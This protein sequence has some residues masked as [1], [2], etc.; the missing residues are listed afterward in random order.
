MTTCPY[1]NRN[2]KSLSMHLCRGCPCSLRRYQSDK[3]KRSPMCRY[4]SV[5]KK[6]KNTINTQT[7]S[8]DGTMLSI[9]EMIRIQ[10]WISS[11]H[12]NGRK[13]RCWPTNV[14]LIKN[15]MQRILIRWV[16]GGIHCQ[17]RRCCCLLVKTVPSLV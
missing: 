5:N 13:C 10:I 1:C 11:N 17:L 4:Q 14:V 9:R 16:D 2:F 8:P 6:R 3:K 12:S 15:G 7:E